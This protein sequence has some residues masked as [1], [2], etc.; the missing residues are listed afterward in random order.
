MSAKDELRAEEQALRDRQ[1]G[2]EPGRNGGKWSKGPHDRLSSTF[3]RSS[4]GALRFPSELGADAFCGLAGEI[5]RTIEPYTEADA[6][7]LL[8]TTLTM[9]GNAIGRGPHFLAGDLEHATNVFVC[10]VGET[11]VGRKGT[12]A[13]AI[14]RPMGEADESWR[15]C[16]KSGLVSGEGVIHAVRDPRNERRKPRKGEHPDA[17]GL[18]EDV[19]D[20]GA[21]DKRLLALLPEFA[22]IL[23]V[24]RRKDNTLSA[25]LR[26]LWDRGEAQTLSKNAP[27]RATGALVSVLAHITP[28]ELRATLDS[29]DIANGFANRFLFIAS[30]RA[31]L[32]S[33]GGSVPFAVRYALSPRITD[34]L[35]HARG[36]TE[37][38][39][40]DDAWELWDGQYERL[41]TPPPGL[42]GAITARAAPLVRRLALLYAL[43]DQCDQVHVEHLRAAFE[44]W[45]Y[46]E[47]SVRWV[48]GDRLGDRIA[49]RCLVLL[50]DAGAAGMSRTELRDQLGHREAADRIADALQLLE[51]A[52]L[53]RYIKEPTGGR[54]AER[55]FAIVS[56]QAKGRDTTDTTDDGGPK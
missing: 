6:A 5:V 29:T 27:E 50:R 39:T 2:A 17:D 56:E 10:V 49:D 12:S 9:F 38:A 1:N 45:R 34:A 52:A 31:R 43:M 28:H 41:A 37:V 19:V 8:V 54:S 36:L 4:T 11:G 7:A 32:L 16:I 33:R 46:A 13:E 35:G 22:S 40:S 24:F 25:V 3:L 30:K 26:D 48:F 44:V 14:R 55:W 53:A 42:V 23:S 51:D 15:P 47:E 18:V 21:E 20:A